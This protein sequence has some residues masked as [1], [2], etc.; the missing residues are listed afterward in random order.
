MTKSPHFPTRARLS[1]TAT[2]CGRLRRLK[3]TKTPL[4][5]PSRPAHRPLLLHLA[6]L[7]PTCHIR[8]HSV[9]SPPAPNRLPSSALTSTVA[10]WHTLPKP[11]SPRPLI[12]SPTHGTTRRR[13]RRRLS[14]V[15]LRSHFLPFRRRPW[16]GRGRQCR[17]R[18]T[19]S[20]IPGT[21]PALLRRQWTT[22]PCLRSHPPHMH[23]LVSVQAR[24]HLAGARRPRLPLEEAGRTRFRS[25]AGALMM[26]RVLPQASSRLVMM[27][28]M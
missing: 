18:Y 21:I 23:T 17:H 25:M 2:R 9:A 4:S 3:R 24:S 8:A 5:A 13:A 14:M 27:T 26:L 10:V 16:T 15:G 20:T 19:L 7:L 12:G 6:R 1:T 28:G 11:L 22:R